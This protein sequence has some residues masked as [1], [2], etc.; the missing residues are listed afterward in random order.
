MGQDDNCCLPIYNYVARPC[1]EGGGSKALECVE[2][3]ANSTLM[4]IPY[5]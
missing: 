3:P 1:K 4:T 5:L 2:E